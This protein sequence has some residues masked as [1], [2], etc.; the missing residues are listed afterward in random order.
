MAAAKLSP[1][2]LHLEGVAITPAARIAVV[3]DLSNN[4]MLHLA[5][6]MKHQGWELTSITATSATFTRGE[7]RQELTLKVD[8]KI[9]R[10]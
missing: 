5:K 10:R 6:G 2:R 8:G 1:V 4:K 7:Q 3:R 9:R